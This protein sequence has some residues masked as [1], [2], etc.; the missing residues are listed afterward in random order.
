[1]RQWVVIGLM[2][3]CC[4]A[5]AMPPAMRVIEFR[6][7]GHGWRGNRDTGSPQQSKAGFSVELTGGEDP[8]IEG[9]Y[10]RVPRV[11]G[12]EINRV[13]LSAKSDVEGD[14]ELFYT[15][16]G[17]WFTAERKVVLR[18]LRAGI[19]QYTGYVPAVGGEV[20]YR[21]DPPG[22]SGRVVLE[23]MVVTPMR[24]L[25][26]PGELKP[27][28]VELPGD[29]LRVRSGEVEVV[30]H[31][32]RWNE[33]VWYVAG[34]RMGGTDPAEVVG[35]LGGGGSLELDL[36]GG[37]VEV[38]AGDGGFGVVLRVSDRDGV[39]WELARSFR[40][41]AGGVEVDC[42][43]RVNR[44]RRVSHL[45]WL[46][47]WAGLG[48]FGVEKS[49]AI[50]PGVEYLAGEPSSNELAV[51]GRAA[52]RRMVERHKLCFP[53]MAVAGGG[54]WGSVSWQESGVEVA[55]LFDSPDRVFKTEAH[56]MGLWT[57]AV[58]S[59]RFES[60]LEV[61]EATILEP[62]QEYGCRVVLSGG[63]GDS[64]AA[65]VANYIEHEGLVE[66]PEFK[67]GFEGAVELLAAG[68]L[69]SKLRE[70]VRWRHA[71]WG[72]S[73][74]PVLAEDAALYMMWL[75]AHSGSSGLRERL[76][77]A[78]AESLAALP[79]GRSGINNT[80]SHVKPLAS[81]LIYGSPEVV[82]KGAES[83]GLRLAE[84]LRD[85]RDIYKAGKVDYAVTLG[86]D[87]CNGFTAM[88]MENLLECATRTGR[89]EVRAGALVAYNKM[90]AN[91]AG[92]VPRGAQPWEMPLQTPDIVA[93]GRLVR[94]G[95]LAY[96][97]SGNEKYIEEARYWAWCGASM[98]YLRPP[99]DGEIG[100]YA[101]I[102]VIGATNWEAPI[103][104]GQPVQWCGLVYRSALVELSRIDRK[105]GELW[106]KIASGIT[107]SG[108]QM[109]F[110]LD[111]PKGRCGLL[112]DFV[113]LVPQQ[114]DGP[115]IN[116]GTLQAHLAEAYGKG[117]LYTM[118]RLADGVLVH[119]PGEVS[120]SREGGV[121]RLEL[122]CWPEEEYAVLVT[123]LEKPERVRWQGREVEGKWLEGS[124]AL[125]VR[126]RGS[127]VL[128]F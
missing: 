30:H 45:P 119:V 23:S 14:F 118:T 124:G 128:E 50:L 97:L 123:H 75:A 92:E 20:K 51:R 117:A 27:Q 53:M 25:Y 57:P 95:V 98:V 39:E 6:S 61:Y 125:V 71:L 43:V 80:I 86:S 67:P 112:P 38:E 88:A 105:H 58:G 85:G 78:V 69:D 12:V 66:L 108:L 26:K 40:G 21:L 127:G 83:E 54:V 64:M 81:A 110:P 103:W 44:Q 17:G 56:L 99:V 113:Y 70:G 62:G 102:G 106:N 22:T 114:C 126:L 89:A 59:A 47:L 1:M 82:V 121:R 19:D 104:I 55:A 91:Y 24:P 109:C 34:K 11:E 96:M 29:A 35:Y 101:T 28:V 90:V 60:E 49:Q 73:F 116:P 74:G 18:R 100:V 84:R 122:E 15:P 32:Q 41:V 16:E 68:W 120:E 77:Q 87:N 3:V 31:P 13:V 10:I 36:R 7:E 94:C 52:R 72:E 42:R 79:E 63:R 111:D 5:M 93:A 65:A 2:G 8:W 4:M 37:R 33:V 115:A 48:S 76:Q 9:P 107:L 46:T